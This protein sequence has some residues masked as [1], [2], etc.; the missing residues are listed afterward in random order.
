MKNMSTNVNKSNCLPNTKDYINNIFTKF[1]MLSGD[2]LFG[3]DPSIICG[4]AY[5][6]EIPVTIIGQMRGKNLHEQIEYNYSMAYP[7]GFRKSLRIMK[8]AEKFGRPIICFVDTA[9]AFPGQQA[10]SRGQAYAI[11]NNIVEML[12][13]KTPII[14]IIVGNGVSGGALALCVADRIAILEN[15]VFS[16]ISPKAYAKIVFKDTNKWREA[17]K[18]LRMTALDMQEQGIVDK[19]IFNSEKND[20]SDIQELCTKIQTYLYEE[21]QILQKINTTKLIKLRQKKF[22]SF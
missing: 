16:V 7:E 17:T 2:R 5:L 9:G 11:A 6:K 13:L 15:A 1:V 8:Q 21:V 3:D 4:I 20:Y 19:I 14:S 22:C 12:S 18:L 10:E